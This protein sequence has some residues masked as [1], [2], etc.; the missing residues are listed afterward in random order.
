M[1]MSGIAIS[2]LALSL[3]LGPART[4]AEAGVPEHLSRPERPAREEAYYGE[5]DAEILAQLMWCEASGVESDTER[6]C[7]AWTVLNRLDSPDFDGGT[8]SEVVTAPGQFYYF[9]WAPVEEGLLELASDVLD[10]WN[11]EKNGESDSGRVIPADYFW[12][13]GDGEHNYFRNAYRG[14][15]RWDYSLQTPYDS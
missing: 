12:Y 5:G 9:A 8:V 2:I 11:S 1:M 13:S 6:A 15:D 7:V 4:G 14:G 3:A 10:R